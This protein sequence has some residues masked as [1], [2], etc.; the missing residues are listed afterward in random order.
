MRKVSLSKKRNLSLREYIESRTMVDAKTGCWLWRRARAGWAHA[1][2][3]EL[4]KNAPAVGYA[5]WVCFFGPVPKAMDV[6]H[7]C[8]NG[9]CANPMHLF[10]GTR[11]EN[12]QDCKAKNRTRKSRAYYEGLSP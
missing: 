1:R 11:K 3:K 12:M 10:L 8:D 9:N 7:T 4:G 6:C 5:S 2:H